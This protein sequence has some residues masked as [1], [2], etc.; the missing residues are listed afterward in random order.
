MD[1]VVKTIWVLMSPDNQSY[2]DKYA[3]EV[4]QDAAE[5]MDVTVAFTGR[6]RDTGFGQE[7]EIIVEGKKHDIELFEAC[8]E[9]TLY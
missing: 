5:K 8:L 1:K 4:I 7:K 9:M 3:Q 2:D 6:T